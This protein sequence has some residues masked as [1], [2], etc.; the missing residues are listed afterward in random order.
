MS[1]SSSEDV[2]VCR[3]CLAF[4]AKLY[5]LFDTG[6]AGD[7][8][9]LVRTGA[10]QFDSLP[11][12]ICIYCAGLLL[13]A[14][15]FRKRCRAAHT[16]LEGLLASQDTLTRQSITTIDR[17]AIKQNLIKTRTQTLSYIPKNQNTI[18]DDSLTIISDSNHERPKRKR[19][20]D[21]TE[22]VKTDVSDKLTLEGF[23]SDTEL[24]PD[25]KEVFV[26]TS[27]TV[28]SDITIKNEDNDIESDD[29]RLIIDSDY[30]SDTKLNLLI[31]K[32]DTKKIKTKSKCL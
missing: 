8:E 23:E 30:D 12:F 1:N 10:Y 17:T 11:Q 18:N 5:N 13:K 27:N 9:E 21:V 6:L 3:G 26:D 25:V 28:N 16:A 20:S 29:F 24:V 4:D 2:S 22:D 32:E 19:K 7:F 31:K 14:S 15:A